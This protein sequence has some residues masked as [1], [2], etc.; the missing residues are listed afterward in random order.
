MRGLLV[1][2]LVLAM[3]FLQSCL[4]PQGEITELEFQSGLGKGMASSAAFEATLH[5]ILVKNCA[6]CHGDSG[7]NSLKHSLSDPE[8]SHDVVTSRSLANLNNPSGSTL[9]TKV[10]SNHQCWTNCEDNANEIQTAIENWVNL[11]GS[12]EEVQFDRAASAE[13]FKTTVHPLLQ[14]NCA[15]C[16]GDSGSQS[17]K[18]A[19]SSYTDAH[20]A[21]IDSARVDF[22]NIPNS[23][24]VKRLSEDNHYCWGDCQEN[25]NEM[26]SLIEAW[27][28]QIDTSGLTGVNGAKTD[29]LTISQAQ[30]R[31]PETM[32]GTVVLQA[33]DAVLEGR[34]KIKIDAQA[35][36]LRMIV[37]DTPQTHPKEAT[38][39][40]PLIVGPS[41]GNSNLCRTVEASHIQSG[42][43][44]RYRLREQRRHVDQTGHRF[45]NQLIRANIIR[46]DKREEFRQA[47]LNGETDLERFY[48]R[49]GNLDPDNPDGP[50]DGIDIVRD[51]T[52]VLPEFM[53]KS[54]YDS[55]ILNANASSQYAD[56]FA[57]KHGASGTEYWFATSAQIRS[58]LSMDVKRREAYDDV[59][60]FFVS[61]FFDD[62]MNDPED[63]VVQI[64]RTLRSIGNN[65]FT[66]NNLEE[67]QL[68]YN[69]YYSYRP[70]IDNTLLTVANANDDMGGGIRR[71][72][73]YVHYTM[74][75]GD[76]GFANFTMRYRTAGG[77]NSQET[78]NLRENENVTLDLLNYYSGG[79]AATPRQIRINNYGATVK[80]VFVQNNCFN[81]HGDGS[82]R[83]QFASNNDETSYDNAAAISN[84]FNYADWSQ[85]RPVERMFVDRH[86]CGGPTACDAIGTQ[87]QS[88]LESWD[89]TVQAEIAAAENSEDNG[90]V[91]L[92]EQERTPGRA[93]FKFKVTE[94]G[95]YNV[96]LKVKTA[97]NSDDDIAI[98]ILDEQGRPMDS[99]RQDQSCNITTY[100]DGKSAAA[101]DASACEEWDMNERSEWTWYTPNIDNF[102]QRIKWTLPQGEYTLEVIEAKVNVAIDLVAVSKNQEFNPRDN[103]IDEGFVQSKAPKILSYDIQNLIGQPGKFEIEVIEKESGDAYVF[104][105]PRIVEANTNVRFRDI[106]LL[107]NNQ[108]DF[109]NSTYTK[110]DRVVDGQDSGILTAAALMALH[111]GGPSV[112]AFSFVF[113]DIAATDQAAVAIDED[114]PVPFLGR[115]CQ[116]LDLFEKS[117][118]PILNNFKLMFKEDYETYT[119]SDS[120]GFPG[121]NANAADVPTIYNCTTCHNEDHPY[122]KMTTFVDGL[123]P[124]QPIPADGLATL[125]KQALSRVDFGNFERSLLLRGLNGTFNHPKLHFIQDAQLNNAGSNNANFAKT[126][127]D[128]SGYVTQ[129]IGHRFEKW[130]SG[131]YKRINYLTYDNPFVNYDGEIETQNGSISTNSNGIEVYN[132]SGRNLFNDA[133]ESNTTGPY[134]VKSNCVD[135]NFVNSGGII[136]DPCNGNANY[137]TEFEI[138]KQKYRD[139]VINWMQQEKISYDNQD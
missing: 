67:S 105:A 107:I 15:G 36:G 80:P 77:T 81:C 129:F 21:V 109:G 78:F 92:S 74:D 76:R 18:H 24:L 72:D 93:K 113:A 128:P 96:W 49:T 118:M 12:G 61:I 114:N 127:N 40:D 7:S 50:L 106:K 68:F 95:D 56:F 70:G 88:A 139:A 108:F 136:Q 110:L 82:G 94:A 85:A 3:G 73:T 38:E 1:L 101:I 41:G 30:I 52:R 13:V 137:Q 120:N 47:L 10:R 44:G 116:N 14:A 90:V 60:N 69:H 134:K 4:E 29:P 84:F 42:T 33:E 39:R 43:N 23:R 34:Y 117:V 98:R 20:D 26:Q 51:I 17:P 32:G 37:G 28:S 115:E 102:N 79:G 31:L 138:L 97:D 48:L 16:H 45:Y 104:R 86:N 54:T 59:R 5:P 11:A 125:C 55:S 58:Q 66:T 19:V 57:P 83:P 75:P 25:A 27:A 126:S 35:S 124:G 87:L 64:P 121:R 89:T 131:E 8:A 9:V 133:P 46:P 53:E 62:G 132:P 71:I 91:A 119:S 65:N 123:A 122:F 99:C 22:A 130:P 100:H 2:N 6:G 112:D 135:V 63:T 111:I 103:L